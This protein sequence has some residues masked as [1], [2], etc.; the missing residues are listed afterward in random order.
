M[1]QLSDL[2]LVITSLEAAF[3][4][5]YEY[6]FSNDKDGN[7]VILFSDFFDIDDL[8]YYLPKNLDVV[9]EMGTVTIKK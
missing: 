6:K 4:D 7:I 3:E 1:K 8:S 9:C 2:Q 5:F